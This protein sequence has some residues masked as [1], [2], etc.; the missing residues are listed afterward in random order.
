LRTK[1]ISAN[2]NIKT[3]KSLLAS[4]STLN[5]VGQ[6]NQ[7]RAGS[8]YGKTPGNSRS[9]RLPETKNAHQFVHDAGFASGEHKTVKTFEVLRKPH[10][11]NPRPEGRKHGI[12]LG[13]VALE[14]EDTDGERGTTSHAQQGGVGQECRRR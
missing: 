1:S 13:D 5:I 2:G 9:E 6:E 12:V 7:P 3:A 4:N 11:D 8:Q 10:L 14:G